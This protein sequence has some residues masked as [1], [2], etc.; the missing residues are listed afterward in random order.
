[1]AIYHFAC[2][3][4]G[5]NNGQSAVASAAYRAGDKLKEDES[6][7]IKNYKR[8]QGVAY[9]EIILPVNAPKEYQDREKLWNA[10]HAIEKNKN[11][12]LAREINVALPIE[13]NLEQC[14]ELMHMYVKE[15]FVDNGM[16]AD[17]SIHNNPGNPH[18]HIMLTMR[19]LKENGEWDVKQRKI[20]VLD[21]EGNR[22]P[23][24]DRNGNQKKDKSGRKQWKV[25]I[26]K[27]TDWDEADSFDKWRENWAKSCN[28]YLE[29]ENQIDHR[30][31]AE[32][33]L[34][35]LPTKHLGVAAAAMERRGISTELGDHN[36]EIK[37]INAYI[38]RAKA[39]LNA[40]AQAIVDMQERIRE[41]QDEIA[42]RYDAIISGI[43]GVFGKTQESG[44]RERQSEGRKQE[45]CSGTNTSLSTDSELERCRLAAAKSAAA[46]AERERK[47]REARAAEARIAEAKRR[48]EEA[49]KQL[50]FE[51]AAAA[52]ARAK[53]RN[54]DYSR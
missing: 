20:N 33:G 41:E 19:P 50:E 22:I 10:V 7:T 17:W 28:R 15:N 21:K 14:K 31:N 25:E 35:E 32:R 23:L 5:R 2:T 4:I 13:I 24:L 38:R 48:A 3:I 30:S 18:A 40:E 8:K 6:Q 47:E 53:A 44:S 27:T 42:R 39:E 34:D 46:R 36:R 11:A 12:Q 51:R 29:P 43:R 16:C 9:S 52:R 49:S 26:V 54:N 37:K 45:A 1:M